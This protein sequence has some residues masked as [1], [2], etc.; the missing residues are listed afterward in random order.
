ML[1][2]N[3][4][5]RVHDSAAAITLMDLRLTALRE[6]IDLDGPKN[7]RRPREKG[8]TRPEFALFSGW[9]NDLTRCEVFK[10]LMQDSDH[11]ALLKS[12]RSYIVR[13]V[14]VGGHVRLLE[15]VIMHL[16]IQAKDLGPGFTFGPSLRWPPLW[17]AADNGNVDQVGS[18]CFLHIVGLRTQCR[19]F[20]AN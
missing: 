5:L 6:G 13:C 11:A 20:P 2:V 18:V 15:E 14:C 8:R 9:D 12:M 4:A 10:T 1:P 3:L 7:S 19:L 17:V 16:G